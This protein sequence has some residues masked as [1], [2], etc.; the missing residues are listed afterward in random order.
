MYHSVN[1][2]AKHNFLDPVSFYMFA[3][4]NMNK[5]G[6]IGSKIDRYRLQVHTFY[7][8]KLIQDYKNFKQNSKKEFTES[9]I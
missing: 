8:D 7:V 3:Y 5:Y 1:D 2:V 9:K 6:I 4:N